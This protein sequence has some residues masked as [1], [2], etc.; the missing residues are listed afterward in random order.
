MN[1]LSRL[2]VCAALISPVLV[3]AQR[4]DGVTFVDTTAAAGIRFVHNNGATG[5]KLSPSSIS[6]VLACRPT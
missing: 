1:L 4:P 3:A 5:D 2:A 6:S